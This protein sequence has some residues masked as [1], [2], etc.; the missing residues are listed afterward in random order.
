MHLNV[1]GKQLWALPLITGTMDAMIYLVH[2]KHGLKLVM[3]SYI[4]DVAILNYL[5]VT[6]VQVC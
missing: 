2:T 6:Q 4:P 1:A 3:V 5:K